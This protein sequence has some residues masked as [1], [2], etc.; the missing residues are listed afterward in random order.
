MPRLAGKRCLIVGGTSGIGLAA[1]RRFHQEGAALVVAGLAPPPDPLPF[2]PCDA[3]VPAEVA[4]LFAQVVEMLG[5]LDVLFHVAGGSGRR[6][7]DGPLHDCTDDGWHATIALN[8]TS[9]FLTNR[10]AVRH[11]LDR[12]Q[13]G[14]I[15]NTASVLPLSPSPRFFD[16]CAY[17]AAKGGVLALSRQAAARYAPDSI[18]VNVLAPG[19]IDT[20]MARRAVQNPA[21]AAFLDGKQPLAPG[22]G[23]PEDCSEAAVFLCSDEA[24]LITGVVL[25]IDGGWCVSEGPPGEDGP[26]EVG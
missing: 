17:T 24:R 3:T 12:R 25:P 13:P 23:R 15:L 8:L 18:R 9:T 11:F 14:V 21:V 20:P 5:G 10:A 2:V 22:P 1:A 6:H 19:L 26:R 16:T 4:Q 7:G